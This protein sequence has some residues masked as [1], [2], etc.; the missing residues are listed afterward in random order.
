MELPT[1]TKLVDH[2]RLRASPGSNEVL[3]WLPASVREAL[4]WTAGMAAEVSVQPPQQL[5]EIT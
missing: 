2:P 3:T 5:I 4:E 1:L